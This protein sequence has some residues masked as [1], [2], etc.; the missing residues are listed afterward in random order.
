M[1][2]EQRSINLQTRNF[3]TQP[4]IH[5]YVDF[6]QNVDWNIMSII[7]LKMRNHGLEIYIESGFW[8]VIIA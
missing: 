6:S 5:R 1:N 2:E 8:M 3:P 7:P 4:L